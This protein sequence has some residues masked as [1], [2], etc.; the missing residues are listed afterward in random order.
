MASDDKVSLPPGFGD[1]KMGE[2]ADG[3]KPRMKS[4]AA[5]QLLRSKKQRAV[6]GAKGQPYTIPDNELLK[7]PTAIIPLTVTAAPAAQSVVT[8]TP[9]ATKRRKKKML[10]SP[11]AEQDFTKPHNP[12]DDLRNRVP[13]KKD[14]PDGPGTTLGGGGG[15][16][17]KK[18][19]GANLMLV[20]G[21][22]GEMTMPRRLSRGGGS[23]K[24]LEV[25]CTAKLMPGADVEEHAKMAREAASM[26]PAAVVAKLKVAK[27][28]SGVGVGGGEGAAAGLDVV[29]MTPFQREKLLTQCG[30]RPS[31]LVGCEVEFGG[32]G[33]PRAGKGGA[34]VVIG[35]KIGIVVGVRTSDSSFSIMQADG[36]SPACRWIE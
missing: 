31:A 36:G 5:L 34:G 35:S 13:R 16:S 3:H 2:A 33:S 15:L 17:R 20:N 22:T 24:S 7:I 1:I 8:A 26:Q 27:T 28:D 18:S 10:L 4:K 29:G 23:L 12:L 19:N 30:A 21:I 32:L 9:T 6:A 14:G 11:P 25:H